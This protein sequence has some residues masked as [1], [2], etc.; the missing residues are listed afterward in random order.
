MRIARD[1]GAMTSCNF[2]NSKRVA[3]PL[4]AV[5][6]RRMVRIGLP[7]GIPQ[8]L[9]RNFPTENVEIVRLSDQLDHDV[10]VEVWIPPMFGWLATPMFQHL[11]GVKFVQC[12]LA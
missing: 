7:E 8:D 5:Y 9:L 11:H 6:H 3:P 4:S 12:L 10:E 1:Y 2:I